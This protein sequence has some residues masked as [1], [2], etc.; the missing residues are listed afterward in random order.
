[1]SFCEF[2][3]EVLQKF[4][5]GILE[6]LFLGIFLGEPS[7]NLE[8]LPVSSGSSPRVSSRYSPRVYFEN[9][10][11]GNSERLLAGIPP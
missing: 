8:N 2:F 6:K 1:M 3:L 4:L 11:F 7:W 5:L 10:L 9:F